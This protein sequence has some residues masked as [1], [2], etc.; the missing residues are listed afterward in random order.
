MS[1]CGLIVFKHDHQLGN[2][3]AWKLFDAVTV[4]K[5]K[6]DTAKP[7]RS[8]ND[9]SVRIDESA[10]PAGVTMDVKFLRLPKS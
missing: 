6:T 10:I 1:P 4:E 3:P 7:P 8:V 9:F 5:Q 2:A